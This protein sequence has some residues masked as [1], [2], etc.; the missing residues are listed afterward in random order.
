M[1]TN[2]NPDAILDGSITKDKIAD[3]AV[4]IDKLEDAV[5]EKLNGGDDSI[6]RVNAVTRNVN[7][8][9][10]VYNEDEDGGTYF[11][12]YRYLEGKKFPC[13]DTSIQTIK[14]AIEQGKTVI[15]SN[16]LPNDNFNSSD[17]DPWEND[18]LGFHSFTCRN[19]L[20]TSTNEGL[21]DISIMIDKD[22]GHSTGATIPYIELLGTDLN[23]GC[24]V[25]VRSCYL[26]S[27]TYY[28]LI[29]G[30]Q[31]DFFYSD[32]LTLELCLTET[33]KNTTTVSVAGK[34]E[35]LEDSSSVFIVNCTGGYGDATHTNI[36]TDKTAEEVAAAFNA[37]RIVH[38][39]GLTLYNSDNSG[40]W[41][42]FTVRLTT[43]A[44]SNVFPDREPLPAPVV[45]VRNNHMGDEATVFIHED[46][47]LKHSVTV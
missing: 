13:F 16:F 41:E 25:K 47:M 3:K 40:E 4:S 42:T 38:Y 1:S 24:D 8:A 29:V 33:L 36:M 2:I 45:E 18:Y 20:V 19:M 15:Y 46:T 37:G 11:A 35:A 27:L 22:A 23:T 12:G 30:Y 17:W 6:L 26:E 34:V 7:F 44:T 9:Y 39:V 5:V 28:A 31:D 10:S 43:L 21:L 32:E 14:E